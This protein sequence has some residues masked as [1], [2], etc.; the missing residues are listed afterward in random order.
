MKFRII[1]LS[2]AIIITPIVAQSQEKSIL[3]KNA[4]LHIGNGE[5]I[6][7]AAV[8]IKD[9]KI[10]LVKN[11]LAY[12]YSVT[13]WDTIIDVSGM[14]IYP[15]FVAPN[16]TLGLTEIDAVRATNDFEEVGVFNPHIRSQIAFNASSE[17]IKTVRSNGIL[18][19]QPTPRGGVISGSSSVMR[20]DG[21]NWEDATIIDNDG[22]HI[23]WPNSTQRNK[24]NWSQLEKS[25]GY[26]ILVEEVYSFFKASLTYANDK[27]ASF[28]SRYEA[29]KGCF[30]NE[31]RVY[32]HANDLQQ[33]NDIIE[34]SLYFNLKAPVIIGGYDAAIVGRKLKDAKIS[35]MLYRT[36]SLPERDDDPIFQPYMTA[37]AL[38]DEGVLFCIQNEGDMEAM[39]ARNIPFLAGTTRAF[40]LTEEQAISAITLNACK[41]LGIDKNYGSIEIGKSA[42][43]FVS[44]GNALEMR[45]NNV[46][47]AFIDGAIVDLNNRQKELYIKYKRK[48]NKG[49]K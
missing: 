9:G 22:I 17:V 48:Y 31:K 1:I 25:K 34:F 2:I 43:L 7:S 12:S 32:F 41:I 45:T 42:T 20:M 16:S 3:I 4:F 40:G 26:S 33:L 21:W 38:Q 49:N 28:D 27:K 24:N 10:S 37:S 6:P 13:D 23:N 46:I 14:H 11:S 35:V 5:T 15:G 39:N 44:E 8:G 18:I 36:H 47:L 30:L 29:M 19:C